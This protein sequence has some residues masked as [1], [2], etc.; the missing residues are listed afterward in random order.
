MRKPRILKGLK[1]SGSF[2]KYLTGRM[3]TGTWVS[4]TGGETAVWQTELG[5]KIPVDVYHT[6]CTKCSQAAIAAAPQDITGKLVCMV[7]DYKPITL[8]YNC[9]LHKL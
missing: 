7:N 1:V 9:P 8:D 6:T 4:V 5:D 3:Q 2:R